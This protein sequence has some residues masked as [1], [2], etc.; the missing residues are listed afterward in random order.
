L[1]LAL[2][3]HANNQTEAWTYGSFSYAEKEAHCH[4][5]SEAL[6]GGGAQQDGGPD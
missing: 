2:V 6:G 5:S 1:F 3:E 4:Q